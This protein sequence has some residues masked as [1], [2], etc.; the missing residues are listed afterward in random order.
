MLFQSVNVFCNIGVP[1]ALFLKT[2]KA[3]KQ[4]TKVVAEIPPTQFGNPNLTHTK[5]CCKSRLMVLEYMI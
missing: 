3:K 2:L 1:L 5:L 4:S